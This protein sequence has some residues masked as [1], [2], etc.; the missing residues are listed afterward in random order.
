MKLSQIPSGHDVEIRSIKIDSKFEYEMELPP[1]CLI[2]VN[3]SKDLQ[4]S[5]NPQVAQRPKYHPISLKS[6]L[7]PQAGTQE[8]LLT[9]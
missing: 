2:K 5:M 6:M 9:V 3:T 7:R 1:N 4:F 8:V